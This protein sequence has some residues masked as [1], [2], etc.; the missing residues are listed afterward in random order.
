MNEYLSRTFLVK[1]IKFGIVGFSGV[2]IDFGVTY[3]CKE[4][5]KI[6]K[7]IAN[8]IGFT[9]AASSNYI[10]NRTWTFRSNDPDIASEYTE[11]LVISLVGLGIANLIVWLIH[12]RLK[13]NFY[14]SKLFAIGMV[15]IWNFFA[16]YY[17]TFAGQ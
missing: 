2:F 5:L 16:N 6:Q 1:F 13:Q 15:T 8:S 12:S 17:I 3:V 4:W 7:Y 10:L 9:I 14:L 11:F